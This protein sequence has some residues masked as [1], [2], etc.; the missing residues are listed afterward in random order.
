MPAGSPA[1]SGWIRRQPLASLGCAVA[2][3]LPA[4]IA[5]RAGQA[6]GAAVL[7]PTSLGFALEVFP[8]QQRR[9]A[10]GI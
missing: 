5:C 7:M 10:V 4:L 8:P 6:A 9:T 3:D 2:P 1:A